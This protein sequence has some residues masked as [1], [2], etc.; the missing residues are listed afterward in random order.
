MIN[1]NLNLNFN[2]NFNFD[3]IATTACPPLP[4]WPGLTSLQ[5]VQP[6]HLA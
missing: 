6:I 1:L 3:L 5:P 4:S 2:F